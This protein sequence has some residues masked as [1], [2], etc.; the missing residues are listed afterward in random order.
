MP[1]RR[2][3]RRRRRRARPMSHL[4]ALL[5]RNPSLAALRYRYR[6]RRKDGIFNARR[7]RQTELT[8]SGD[9]VKYTWY[10]E[11]YSFDIDYFIPSKPFSQANQGLL[12][13]YYR[14]RK[15]NVEVLP[16]APIVSPFRGYGS[17]AI[18]LDVNYRQGG[19]EKTSAY[20]PCMNYSTRHVFKSTYSYHSR[21]FTPKPRLADPSGLFQPN[22][23]R[24]Q[25][26]LTH[27][28]TEQVQWD[29]IGFAM[30][31]DPDSTD[32]LVRITLYVQYRDFNLKD[33]PLN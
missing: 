6:W 1:F 19:E 20:D 32:Y 28:P 27:Q 31:S 14:I 30:Y 21:Y 7:S 33:P 12:W 29:G 5:R 4:G 8:V 26:W 16:R 15:A 25:F 22:N 3:Y 2:R 17:T 9:Q 10:V 13:M 18:I 23:K 11:H 24:N